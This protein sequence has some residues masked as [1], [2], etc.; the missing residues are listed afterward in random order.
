MAFGPD[1]WNLTQAASSVVRGVSAH[2]AGSP[3]WPNV[4]EALV[5]LHE[6][7]SDWHAA[8]QAMDEALATMRPNAKVTRRERRHRAGVGNGGGRGSYIAYYL[9][10]QPGYIELAQREIEA[11]MQPAAPL[12]QRWS[13]SKRRQAGR[14]SLRSLMSIYC[15]TLLDDFDRAVEARVEWVGEYRRFLDAALDHDVSEQELG[16]LRNIARDTAD[17]LENVRLQL[18]DLIKDQFP[19]RTL[20][21]AQA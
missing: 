1:V 20:N 5:E 3:T 16:N 11:V 13:S 9:K 4:H 10:I 6:I 19:L 18:R 7:V 14:R 8:A 12:A 2:T 17:K 15:E 21:T